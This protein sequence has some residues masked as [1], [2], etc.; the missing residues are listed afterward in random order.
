MLVEGN[1]EGT[2]YTVDL[3]IAGAEA[4][5]VQWGHTTGWGLKI[6]KAGQELSRPALSNIA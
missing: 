1:E 2:H 5:Q 6:L 3:I 4:A